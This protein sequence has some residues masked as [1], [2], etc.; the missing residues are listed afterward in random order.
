MQSEQVE[1]CRGRQSHNWKSCPFKHES[2]NARRRDPT[3]IEY[4]TEACPLYHHG[5]CLFG[6]LLHLSVCSHAVAC[7]QAAL[8]APFCGGTTLRAHEHCLLIVLGWNRND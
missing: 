3:K 1:E 4:T 5:I 7:M 6:A 8:S 2:E